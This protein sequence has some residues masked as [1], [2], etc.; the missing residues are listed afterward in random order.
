MQ[1]NS[2]ISEEKKRRRSFFLDE[3]LF[4]YILDHTSQ[5]DE[6]Q[7]SLIETTS[8][9][10]KVSAMQIAQDQGVFL[11]ML[12]AAIRPDF[13]VEVGTFTGYSSLAIA[14]A[15]PEN[16]KLLCCDVSEEWT[17][18]ANRYWEK[19]GVAE[20]IELVIAPAKETLANLPDGKK[21]D[22]AFIDADKGGYLRYY[23]EIV[24]R[25]SEHGLIAIDNVLWSGKV[26]DAEI[27][28]DDT[29]SMRNF[30]DY[31]AKDERVSSVMLSIGD[32]LT[33]VKRTN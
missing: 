20:K 7:Q 21:I 3:K 2:N 6:T 4:E 24:S 19:A 32:G 5:P 11:Y 17:S 18:V 23:E 1:N 10:G 15:L 8:E 13:A 12:V 16:G 26:V 30:N 22:F 28:D 27:S 9:L 33:L 25:L 29:V 14:K 31:V